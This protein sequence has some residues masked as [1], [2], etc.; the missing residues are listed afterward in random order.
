MEMSLPLASLPTWILSSAATRS[1]QT[2]H[3]HLAEAGVDGYAYRCIAALANL[4]QLSQVALGNAAALDPRDVTHTVR[5]LE[6]RGFVMRKKDPG[7]GRRIL[8]SL[9][10]EGLQ[11]ANQLSRVMADVQDRVFGRLSPEERST[12]LELLARIGN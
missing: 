1:H 12:L 6:K 11:T 9:T 4:G 2:L 5:T 7:H 10:D 3:R 8:V